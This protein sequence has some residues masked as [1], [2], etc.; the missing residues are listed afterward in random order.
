MSLNVGKLN[1][2]YGKCYTC[3]TAYDHGNEHSVCQRNRCAYLLIRFHYASI[4]SHLKTLENAH[5]YVWKCSVCVNVIAFD[6]L[7]SFN[8]RSFVR[9]FAYTFGEVVRNAPFIIRYTRNNWMNDGNLDTTH[10]LFVAGTLCRIFN[11]KKGHS[12]Y[13]S[14]TL[15]ILLKFTNYL[16]LVYYYPINTKNVIV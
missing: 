7:F 8:L 6:E 13:D 14:L 9:S 12:I 16:L 11:F 1:I 5:R 10:C 2:E 15:E 3:Y 4:C